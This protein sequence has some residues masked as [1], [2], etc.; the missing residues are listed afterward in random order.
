[1]EAD[2]KDG[3]K[4]VSN[5]KRKAVWKTGREAVLQSLISNSTNGGQ[6]PSLQTAAIFHEWHQNDCE[7]Q[8]LVTHLNSKEDQ[9]Q[10]EKSL[11]LNLHI[12]G[13]ER[14]IRRAVVRGT[15]FW[16][17]VRGERKYK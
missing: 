3:S 5:G 12:G 7:S 10:N 17:L 1:M 16:G 14:K 13:E 4:R 11:L 2:D 15:E 6:R 9:G 8:A